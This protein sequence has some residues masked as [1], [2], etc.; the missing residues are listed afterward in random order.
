MADSEEGW[1]FGQDA[2]KKVKSRSKL[3]PELVRLTRPFWVLVVVV[4]LIVM[5]LKNNDMS[6]EQL[7]TLGKLQVLTVTTWFTYHMALLDKAELGFSLAFLFEIM[8]R[9]FSQLPHWRKFFQS[10]TNQAD[11]FIAIVTCI[12]QIPPIHDNRPVYAWLTGFQVL[13]IYRVI[14]MIPRLR[15]LTVSGS[16]RLGARL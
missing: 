13:R 2:I 9:L 8:L 14:V 6:E 1:A 16:F 11:F 7:A 4:D 15:T 12:I 5:G 3:L 10:R